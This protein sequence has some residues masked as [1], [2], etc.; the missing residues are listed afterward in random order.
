MGC[1]WVVKVVIDGSGFEKPG[2][3]VVCG[4]QNMLV[5]QILARSTG[6]FPDNSGRDVVVLAGKVSVRVES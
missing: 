4:V 1:S 6:W 5:G 2:S 3:V